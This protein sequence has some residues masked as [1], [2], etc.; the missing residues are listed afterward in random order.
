MIDLVLLLASIFGPLVF[1]VVFFSRWL[2]R[3]YEVKNQFVL[4]RSVAASV[5]P[6]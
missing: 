6:V 5:P 4:V 2:F 3:D 1:A